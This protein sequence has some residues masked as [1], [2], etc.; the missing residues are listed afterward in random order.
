MRTKLRSAVLAVL[1]SLSLATAG[2]STA[3][4]TKTVTVFAAASMKAT[5]TKLAQT[6]EASHPGV[7]VTFNF[8]NGDTLA[9]QITQGAPADVFATASEAH[10]K[11]ITDAGL[12]AA[13]VKIYATNQLQIAVP[14][15]NPAKIAT[16]AD[17]AGGEVKF[18]GCSASTAC[19]AATKK[20]EAGTGVT[21]KPVSEEETVTD[22]LA[23][24]VAG[25]ADAGLV[26]R[27]DVSSAGD[28]VAG[29]EFP[30][31]AKAVNRNTIVALKAGPQAA[32]GQE[33]VDLVVS[34][35]GQQ[36][37]AA[38]GFGPGQ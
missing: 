29:I 35:E 12:G 20:I 22:V 5:F 9:M 19:G 27:T 26:F 14:P 1:V 2:C 11:P 28:K 30:E 24:V 16:F 4:T 25:E 31:S 32:L 23:K 38:A 33:F 15:A 10:L 7:K 21:L 36:V 17:L 6:F 3:A 8:A 18:V 34:A 13:Q 37:L